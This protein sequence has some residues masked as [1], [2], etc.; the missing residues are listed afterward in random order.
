MSKAIFIRSA[1]AALFAA[2]LVPAI[3]AAQTR[4][5]P[6]F[7]GR[8]SQSQCTQLELSVGLKGDECGTLSLSELA[9]IKADKED[10]K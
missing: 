2:S 6:G 4:A 9:F 7:D 3:G 1:T 10:S 5:V 8:T